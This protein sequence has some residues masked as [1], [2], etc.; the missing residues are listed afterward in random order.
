MRPNIRRNMVQPAR[1]M[2]PNF[3][4]YCAF[5]N[6]QGVKQLAKEEGYKNPPQN[7]IQGA[8]V[9][10]DI[11]KNDK[12]E[13]L[14]KIASIHPDRELIIGTVKTK[15]VTNPDINQAGQIFADGTGQETTSDKK[16]FTEKTINTMIIGGAVVLGLALMSII[17]NKK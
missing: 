1:N 15:P 10:S 14:K 17:L 3:Y 7:Y 11:V 16:T 2:E 8:E 5:F 12:E 6:P 13:G 9:L 4:M